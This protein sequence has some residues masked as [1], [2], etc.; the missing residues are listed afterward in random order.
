MWRLTCDPVCHV[1][2]PCRHH[3]YRTHQCV[4]VC[5]CLCVRV[6]VCVSPEG[7]YTSSPPAP[8]PCTHRGCCFHSL[9]E[10]NI[11]DE[12]ARALAEVLPRCT[13][14]QTFESVRAHA[15]GE[16]WSAVGL[17]GAVR[18]PLP[19]ASVLHGSAHS[20]TERVEGWFVLEWVP[21]AVMA[22]VL[23]GVYG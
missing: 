8:L 15:G 17:E 19:H 9:S 23:F 14:L 21:G 6:C 13:A 16:G 3:P 10:S 7:V 4:Y 2:N 20:A 5:L 11:G 12:G 22:V 18:V 1:N